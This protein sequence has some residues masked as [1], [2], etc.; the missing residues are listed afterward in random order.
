[1]KQL[2]IWAKTHPW[3][4]RF[5]IVVA[6]IVLTF[7]A[8]TLGIFAA[9][10]GFASSQPIFFLAMSL[11]FG[12]VLM[13]PGA[14]RRKFKNRSFIRRKS[15]DA[16]LLLA[17]FIL[18]FWVGLKTPEDH[19]EDDWSNL[20]L[21][22]LGKNLPTA[23]IFAT[24]TLPRSEAAMAAEP[25]QKKVSF[26]KK[27]WMWKTLKHAVKQYVETVRQARETRSADW[28]IGL[29]I[30]AYVTL[31]VLIG[32]L[33]TVLACRIACN[34]SPMGALLVLMGGILFVVFLSILVWRAMRD[35]TT[36]SL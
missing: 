28:E 2:A 29:L 32:C 9:L 19:W 17:S 26:F 8:F 3:N 15:C 31:V 1:M 14:H 23:P 4:A 30:L 16:A 35:S 5:F 22:T 33:T 34:G 11:F 25:T 10:S 7:M 27:L 21:T 12:A 18:Y 24:S 20:P 13:Y 36:H 6:H